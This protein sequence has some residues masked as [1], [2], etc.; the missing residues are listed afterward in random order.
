MHGKGPKK[1]AVRIMKMPPAMAEVDVSSYT[2]RV[3]RDHGAKGCVRW[4]FSESGIFGHTCVVC[5]QCVSCEGPG[6][7]RFGRCV[8]LRMPLT[9][10]ERT[11]I[12][13]STNWKSMPPPHRHRYL[14]SINNAGVNVSAID[15]AHRNTL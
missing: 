5:G 9:D 8:A 1:R 4:S 11:A 13:G 10:P 12:L 14:P 7:N 6:I 3:A 2:L 15:P